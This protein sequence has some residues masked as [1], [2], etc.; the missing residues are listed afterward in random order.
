[1]LSSLL[2][3]LTDCRQTAN[4]SGNLHAPKLPPLM[5]ADSIGK[6]N[7]IW[8]EINVGKLT[9][10]ESVV[11]GVAALTAPVLGVTANSQSVQKHICLLTEFTCGVS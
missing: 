5:A 11:G 2:G 6:R 10:R 3:A 8:L 4:T 1:M 7:T 9:R